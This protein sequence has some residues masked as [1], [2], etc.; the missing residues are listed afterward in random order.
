MCELPSDVP[1]GGQV[2]PTTPWMGKQG[3]GIHPEN[4]QGF[5]NEVPWEIT[6]TDNEI[7]PDL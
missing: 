2:K 7:C 6:L 1:C 5:C 3:K 4:S